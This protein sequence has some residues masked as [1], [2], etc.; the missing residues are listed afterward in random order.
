MA[1]QPGG[2]GGGVTP[3]AAV[4]AADGGAD[5]AAGAVASG[6]AQPRSS[7][8]PFGAGQARSDT[9]GQL[10]LAVPAMLPHSADGIV[11]FRTPIVTGPYR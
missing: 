2:N 7:S 6:A 10:L 5:G 9:R 11:S 3:C 8:E 4:G 1:G